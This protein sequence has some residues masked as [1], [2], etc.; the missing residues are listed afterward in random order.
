ML[1]RAFAAATAL[2]V[3]SATAPETFANATCSA[4]VAVPQTP[5]LAANSTYYSDT[6]PPERFRANAQV[7]IQFAGQ[8]TIDKICGKAP[9]NLITLGCQTPKKIILPNP[10]K[11]GSKDAFA[12]LACH[13]LGH[14]NGWPATHGD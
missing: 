3:P 14:L 2:L 1:V 10:C 6:M 8:D 13:E 12:E 11:Y 9:C 7:T 5:G 4:P